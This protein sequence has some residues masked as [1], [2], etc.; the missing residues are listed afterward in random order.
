MLSNYKET[1][2]NKVKKMTKIIKDVTG[3]SKGVSEAIADA[4]VRGRDVVRLALQKDWPID[5][6]IITGPTGSIDLNRLLCKTEMV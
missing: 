4:I 1:K 3:L 6:D 2:Q 5:A